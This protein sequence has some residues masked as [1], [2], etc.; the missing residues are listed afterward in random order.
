MAEATRWRPV[1]GPKRNGTTIS[2]EDVTLPLGAWRLQSLRRR[3]AALV[4]EGAVEH[5]RGGAEKKDI[6]RRRTVRIGG[7]EAGRCPPQ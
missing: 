1:H 2:A 4:C 7:G 6:R 5:S 3:G